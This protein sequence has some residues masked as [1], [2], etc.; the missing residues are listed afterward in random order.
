MFSTRP[1]SAVASRA[2]PT[3]VTNIYYTQKLS[4]FELWA[5]IPNSKVV[6]E[7]AVAT[8]ISCNYLSSNYKKEYIYISIYI[9]LFNVI[10]I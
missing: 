8:W 4:R 3:V 9:T 6:T 10:Y 2:A 5:L 1:P 7:F